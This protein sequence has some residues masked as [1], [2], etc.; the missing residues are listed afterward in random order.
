MQKDVIHNTEAL[1]I[2]A[3]VTDHV[4]R[5][6]AFVG[7]NKSRAAELLNVDRRTLQRYANREE[8]VGPSE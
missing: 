1:S 5:V 8:G 7:G 6:L 4:R 2:R 3:I